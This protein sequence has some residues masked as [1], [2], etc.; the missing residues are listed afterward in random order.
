MIIKVGEISFDGTL[1]ELEAVARPLYALGEV[2][3]R[4]ALE[5]YGSDAILDFLL[6]AVETF[7]ASPSEEP[8]TDQE[9]G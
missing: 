6:Q 5:T 2:L 9:P 3:H 4:G 8:A 7:R 1:E